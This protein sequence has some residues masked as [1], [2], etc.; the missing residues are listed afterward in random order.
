MHCWMMKQM[1]SDTWFDDLDNRVC[2]LIGNTLCCLSKP[3]EKKDHQD[4][5]LEIVKAAAVI[6]QA[7]VQN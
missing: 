4:T 3:H 6:T 1:T 2:S 7:E 5:P